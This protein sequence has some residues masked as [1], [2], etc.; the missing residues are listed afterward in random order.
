MSSP[1][2]SLSDMLTAQIKAGT[3]IDLPLWLGEM[4]SI[5]Y[6]R[7]HP[8]SDAP[9]QLI[10]QVPAGNFSIGYARSPISIVR[11]SDECPES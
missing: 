3:R 1:A 4:L 5:G 10:N 6:A 8:G 11:A 9:S 2:E 7:N